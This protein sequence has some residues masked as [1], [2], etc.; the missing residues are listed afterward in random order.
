MG[1]NMSAALHVKAKTSCPQK[2]IDFPYQMLELEFAPDRPDF[3]GVKWSPR[4]TILFISITC[5]G[6]WA[7]LAFLVLR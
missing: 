5:G 6:F 7:G 1:A 3:G 2:G 4:S